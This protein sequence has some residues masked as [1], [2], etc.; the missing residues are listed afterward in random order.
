MPKT[1]CEPSDL[2]VIIAERSMGNGDP[3]IIAELVSCMENNQI[4]AMFIVAIAMA[5]K[6][7]RQIFLSIKIGKCGTSFFSRTG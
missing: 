5:Y 7:D 6:V 4:N 2:F 1:S 3:S